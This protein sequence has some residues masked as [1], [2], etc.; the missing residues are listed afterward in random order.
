[1]TKKATVKT[2][3][4]G[5]ASNTQLNFNFD[6]LNDQFDN[7]LSLDGSTPNAMGADLDM[8]SNNITNAADVSTNTL[9]VAGVLVT[10]ATYVPNWEGPWVTTKAYVINDLVSEAGSSYICLVAHTSGTFSTDLAANKWELFAQQG[11]A[12]AGTGDM[13]AANNLSDVANTDTS[14]TNLGGGT[15]GIAIF[16]DSTAAAVRTELGLDAL[17]LLATVDTAQ[18]DDDAV[19]L[20]K[21]AAGTDGE[22]ITWDASGDPATVGVGT[23]AQV[24]TSNGV[25][26]APTFQDSAG[27]GAWTAGTETVISSDATADFTVDLATYKAVRFLFRNVVPATDNVDLDM[28]ASID[29]GSNYNRTLHKDTVTSTTGIPLIEANGS[30]TSEWGVSGFVE[31]SQLSSAYG[32]WIQ[33]LVTEDNSGVMQSDVVGGSINTTTAITNIRFKMDSGNLESGTIQPFYLTG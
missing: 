16:K 26:A 10:D 17:A 28:L 5:H 29:S 6:A 3:T 33:N 2:I 24:L 32:R 13:L 21:I 19:T 8:N 9:T 7:T 11:A 18:I 27:G 22:L 15:T 14:L 25:G 12:G 30:G 4:S 23:A 31:V 1:M 20:A